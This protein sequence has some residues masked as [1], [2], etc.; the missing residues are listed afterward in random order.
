MTQALAASAACRLRRARPPRR[1]LQQHPERLGRAPRA[2]RTGRS[3]CRSSAANGTVQIKARAACHRLAVADRDRDALRHRRREP[4]EGGR[5][6]LG[7][8]EA[9][10]RARPSTI[11][12]P[13]S[14]P[15]SP[16]SPTW[17]WC[18]ATAAASPAGSRRSASRCCRFRRPPRWPTPTR[19]TASWAGHRARAR[20][21]R[22]GG[23]HEGADRADRARRAQVQRGPDL[24]LRARPDLLLGDVVDL[25]R[26]GARA[27]SGCAT[28]PTAPRRRRRAAATRSCRRSSSCSPTPTGSS[29]P[30]PSAAG[31]ARTR[32]RPRPGGRR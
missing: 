7:L 10:R 27:S 17:S 28:S 3:R 4:G 31:R 22:R 2:R 18:P 29:W 19:S 13:T 21:P 32:W 16:T 1:L 25:H 24:L 20:R 26:Q 12:S 15:S 23:P 5:Q 11:S 9:A 14:R 6:V 8:P 30:T